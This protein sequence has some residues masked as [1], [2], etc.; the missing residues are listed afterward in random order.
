M[1]DFKFEYE[2]KEPGP[3]RILYVAEAFRKKYT[4]AEVH[5]ISSIDPWFLEQI[6]DLI[7]IEKA[8]SC[9]KIKDLSSKDLLFYKKK[10]FSDIKIANLMRTTQHVVRK[11]RIKN[12]IKPV[13]KIVDTCAAE[14]PTTTSV[15]YTHLTLPTI[16]LV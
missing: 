3:S 4:V 8:I 9:K 11:K 5:K 14:F 10:G 2:L 13:Y 7:E 12:N 1:D 15:S 16:L 6:Y